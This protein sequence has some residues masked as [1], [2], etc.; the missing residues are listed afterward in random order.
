MPTPP[1]SVVHALPSHELVDSVS[2]VS[3][4]HGT[5]SRLPVRTV[6]VLLAGSISTGLAGKHG[7]YVDMYAALLR[8]ARYRFVGYDVASC[9]FPSSVHACDAWLVSGSV[10][11]ANDSD[12]WIGRL[13]AFIRASY[14]AR[15]P[16][17]GV[18]FGHQVIC[19]ALGGK[20]ES[21]GTYAAGVRD[22]EFNGEHT[23][24]VAS[25]GD[26]VV[27]PPPGSEVVASAPYCPY[28]ALRYSNVA[29]SVQPH[30]EF[31]SEFMDDLLVKLNMPPESEDRKR[32]L[33]SNM[34]AKYIIDFLR[35]RR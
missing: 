19:R 5:V 11:S 30:P 34:V 24:L 31:T 26:Q 4:V 12:A 32:V 3:S 10:S 18:C 13:C 2:S 33:K 17:V 28:A 7:S 27:V 25:H 6:G 21:T 9:E 29:F 16:L 8:D 22:Y 15:I 35:L 23:P 14:A 1:A 20:V